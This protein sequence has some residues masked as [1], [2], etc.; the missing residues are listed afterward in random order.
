MMAGETR[1]TGEY[2]WWQRGIVYQVYPRSFQDSNGDG[3]GDLAGITQRL[4]YLRWLGVDA[5]WISPFYPSPMADFGF[6]VLRFW[7]DRGVDG[8]RVDVLWHLIKDDQ[9]R[10][11]PPNPD[12]RPGMDPFQ[13]LLPLQTTDR[14]E[15]HELVAN[16]RRL[17]DEYEER[18]LIG[19]IY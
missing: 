13:A 2:L 8:F 1:R 17:F 15:A 6:D 12:W 18:V 10:D 3:I 9:F 7:L 16:M 11:N 19:E 4:D 5:V 14:P